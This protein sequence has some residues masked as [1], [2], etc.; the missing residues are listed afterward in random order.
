MSRS[1]KKPTKQNAAPLKF[2][3]KPSEVALSAVFR[4]S[5][6]ERSEVAGD[7]MFGVAVMSAWMSVKYLVNMG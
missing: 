5:I 3:P 7:V 2:D 4:T 6:N 1:N